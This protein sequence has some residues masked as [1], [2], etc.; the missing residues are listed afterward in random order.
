ML[1][2]ILGTALKPALGVPLVAAIV[3]AAE[4]IVADRKYGVIHLRR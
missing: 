4:L 1:A 3:A 2:R